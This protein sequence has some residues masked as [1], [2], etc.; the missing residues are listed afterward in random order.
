MIEGIGYRARDTDC[1]TE[2]PLG[3][4][5]RVGDGAPGAASR[6]RWG[7]NYSGYKANQQDTHALRFRI[8]G[9]VN[10]SRDPPFSGR[11]G[12]V[13]RRGGLA[14]RGGGEFWA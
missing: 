12:G 10:R 1:V 3:S 2:Y 11:C 8:L 7:R 13:A 6:E 14:G 9:M 5:G 4:G